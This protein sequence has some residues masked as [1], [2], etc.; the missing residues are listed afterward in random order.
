L[1]PAGVVTRRHTSSARTEIVVRTSK[2]SMNTG[3]A[4]SANLLPSSDPR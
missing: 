4:R 1:M 2:P 3:D